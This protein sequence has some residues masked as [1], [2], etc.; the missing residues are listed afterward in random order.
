VICYTQMTVS[1]TSDAS[2]VQVGLPHGEP[3]IR[4]CSAHGFS[5]SAV[6]AS[7]LTVFC[8]RHSAV[9]VLPY[10]RKIKHRPYLVLCWTPR[11]VAHHFALTHSQLSLV[12]CLLLR[13]LL[14]LPLLLRRRGRGAC[15]R[16][17]LLLR[18]WRE[19][20]SFLAVFRCERCGLGA[21]TSE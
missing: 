16:Q 4:Y 14:R 21:R 6:Q 17:F 5:C 2:T 8:R 13:L 19:D 3:R 11:C 20:T 12:G 15:R 9:A 18:L 1:E 10:R 7:T